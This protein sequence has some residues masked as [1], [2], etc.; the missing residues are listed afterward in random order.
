MQNKRTSVGP[1]GLAIITLVG[2]AALAS[3]FLRPPQVD[4]VENITESPLTYPTSPGRLAATQHSAQTSTQNAARLPLGSN[5]QLP[6]SA[7]DVPDPFDTSYSSAPAAEPQLPAWAKPPSPIDHVISKGTAQAWRH[8]SD[9]ASS[10]LQPLQSWVGETADRVV[11]HEAL[12][13]VHPLPSMQPPQEFSV[14][15]PIVPPALGSLTSA[16]Q[17]VPSHSPPNQIQPQPSAPIASKFV[18]QPGFRL[19]ATGPK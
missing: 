19:P 18:F 5:D 14:A 2:G 8:E 4:L 17:S 3:P 9:A 10:R 16:S 11:H 1:R 6:A 7:S 13:E 12:R 15:P